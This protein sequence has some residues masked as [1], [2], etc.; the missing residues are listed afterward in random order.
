M[1]APALPIAVKVVLGV[2]AA[3]A[4]GFALLT[5]VVSRGSDGFG[6][7]ARFAGL[8]LGSAYLLGVGIAWLLARFALRG[9]ALRLLAAVAA[10]PL[11]LALALLALRTRS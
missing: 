7:L 2:Q 8:L 6:D 4:V 3:L 11:V 10:P 9:T 5:L 1:T